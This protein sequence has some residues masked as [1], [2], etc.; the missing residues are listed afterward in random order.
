MVHEEL[1]VA[2]IVEEEGWE[3]L[4]F[5]IVK[6]GGG[7]GGRLLALVLVDVA[8]VFVAVVVVV[9]VAA[10]GWAPPPSLAPPPSAPPPPP[11]ALV[12]VSSPSL[13]PS[14]LVCP[15]ISSLSWY[16]GGLS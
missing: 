7:L 15:S 16:V 6:G 4:E 12:S 13:S 10:V 9:L 1:E 5:G 11:P 14:G 3:W 2:G 8:L